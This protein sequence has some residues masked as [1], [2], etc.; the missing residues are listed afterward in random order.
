M[1]FFHYVGP[2]EGKHLN[3]VN[4]LASPR[5]PSIS[6]KMSE[7]LESAN[8]FDSSLIFIPLPTS[9]S[10]L[11]FTPFSPF[12]GT[13]SN[14]AFHQFFHFSAP[15]QHLSFYSLFGMF[16]PIIGL[17]CVEK[18]IFYKKMEN[19]IENEREIDDYI[20]RK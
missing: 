19:N 9:L 16:T 7:I 18:I 8:F 14:S 11:F 5:F 2:R 15:L 3:T 13:Q 12:L 20:C 17:F 10:F 6:S 1:I 4:S